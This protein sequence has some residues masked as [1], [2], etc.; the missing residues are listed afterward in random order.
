M[1]EALKAADVTIGGVKPSFEAA[2]VAVQLYLG[3]VAS[4]YADQAALRTAAESFGPVEAA[5]IVHNPAGLSKVGQPGRDLRRDVGKG[6]MCE[7]LF[8]EKSNTVLGAR[9]SQ[10]GLRCKGTGKD[11]GVAERSYHE[12]SCL[13]CAGGGCTGLRVHRVHP[14]GVRGCMQEGPRGPLWPLHQQ[15]RRSF[16]LYRSCTRPSRT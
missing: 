10:G 12:F 3:N 9:Q 6:I 8:N 16:H 7:N 5:F 11:G 1:A 2:H 14:A 13:T 4:Q 15:Q